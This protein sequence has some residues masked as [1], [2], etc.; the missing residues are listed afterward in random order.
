MIGLFA[1]QDPVS[2]VSRLGVFLDVKMSAK[3]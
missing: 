2:V 1:D 3:K